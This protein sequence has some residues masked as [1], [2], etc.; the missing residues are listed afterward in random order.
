MSIRY[1]KMSLYLGAFN[2]RDRTGLAVDPITPNMV[3]CCCVNGKGLSLFDLRMPLPLDL[4]YD[5]HHGIIRDIAF[6]HGSWPWGRGERTLMTVA[7][8]GVCKVVT[9]DGRTLHAVHTNQSLNTVAPT[10]ETYGSAVDD[11]FTSLV[12]L[13]G[14]NISAYI[15]ECGVQ[16]K[17][18]DNKL[19]AP[20]WKLRY[21]SNGSQLF[22]ACDEGV[23]RRY[24]RW[25][26][27]HQYLGEV[28][29]HKNDIEDMDISPYD[30]YLVTSSKDRSVGVYKLGPPNHG[31][32]EYW[33]LT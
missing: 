25:P 4:L 23:V 18:K 26:D 10:P 2:G 24:R 19:D 3:V 5:V 16:E 7:A 13:G 14:E 11:G 6:L 28:F 20:I 9:L 27:H 32:S 29:R 31:V 1:L 15:P 8:D 33:E 21:T 17:L 30:E 12:M 22:S